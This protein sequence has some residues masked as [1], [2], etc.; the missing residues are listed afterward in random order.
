MRYTWKMNSNLLVVLTDGGIQKIDGKLKSSPKGLQR[1][2]AAIN[3][4]TRLKDADIMISG[5]QRPNPK[6]SEAQLL[7]NDVAPAL[8]R[9][10]KYHHIKTFV[11]AE[12]RCTVDD[13]RAL[14]LWL[15][16]HP[17]AK[18][19]ITAHPDHAELAAHALVCCGVKTP[20]ETL[21]T[22]EESPYNTFE[23]AILGF[24]SAVDP[25]WQTPLSWPLRLVVGF[26][27]SGE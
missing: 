24:L 9:L 17:Y 5:G 2:A 22:G 19:K 23:L 21:L 27:G 12:G 11:Q 26:R 15:K 6:N 13:M 25:L 18:I 20:I 7:Y 8:V 4:A 1:M 3:E 14:T 16:S 10:E